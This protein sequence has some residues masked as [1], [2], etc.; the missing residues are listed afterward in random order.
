M[1]QEADD[2]TIRYP[3]GR[4]VEG[5]ILSRTETAMRVA[6]RGSDDVAEFVAADGGWRSER[7]GPVQIEFAW[8]RHGQRNVIAEADCICPSELA[9]RLIDLLLNESGEAHIEGGKAAPAPRKIRG[10]RV[11]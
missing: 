11:A 5:A 6:I 7:L 10:R 9:S 1:V 3:D 2:M 4:T 8:Q